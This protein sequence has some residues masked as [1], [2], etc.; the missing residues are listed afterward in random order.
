MEFIVWLLHGPNGLLRFNESICLPDTNPSPFYQRSATNEARVHDIAEKWI[1]ELE[2]V[3]GEKQSRKVLQ[4]VDKKKNYL[5][6]QPR[7]RL[8]DG[9]FAYLVES[10][11]TN[12]L[13]E[14][15]PFIRY[16]FGQTP[17]YGHIKPLYHQGSH[18]RK[19]KV[20]ENPS[21]YLV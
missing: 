19:I 13:D 12:T 21:L 6:G 10:H 16:I 18:E 17:S 3:I 7:I 1:E 14:L 9:L 15:L 20:S 8:D 5:P 4:A 2:T 11:T